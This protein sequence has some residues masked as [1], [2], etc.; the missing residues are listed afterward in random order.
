MADTPNLGN[1][2]SKEWDR[3]Q[4]LASRFESACR[5]DGTVDLDR[6]L[7][8]VGDPLRQ[9][10]LLELIKTDLEYRWKQGRITGLESYL[11]RYSELNG[12]E[13]VSA[14]L[15]Y[16]EYRVRHLYG[17]R[18][19][20]DTY[21]VRFPKQYAELL[22]LVAEQPVQKTYVAID[23]PT[24]T[25]APPGPPSMK[26]S[27]GGYE[28]IQR[29]G[30]GGFG[31]VWK[32]RS[33]GG[34]EV[35]IKVV[36]RPLE[37]EEAQRELKAME[38]IKLLR[39]PFL[40]QTHD[41]FPERERLYIVME[42]A[43]GSLR[44]RLKECHKAG[45]G[46]IPRA[47]LVTYMLE[48][49][50]ALD[51]LHEENLQHRDIKPE[52][53]L[54]LKR[55]A[56]V[57]DFGLAKVQ[58]GKH[59]QT[60]TGSGTPLYMAP[61]IWKGHVH[62]NS[63]QYSLALT[64]AELRLARRPF[65]GS[66]LMQVMFAHLEKQP[67]LTGMDEAEQQVVLRALSKDPDQ[68]YPSCLA[69]AQAL[70]QA[71][72]SGGLLE[73]GLTTPGTQ[74]MPGGSAAPGRG[75]VTPDGG[76]FLTPAGS[77]K[78]LIPAEP[79]TWKTLDEY[80][81]PTN[82]QQN[83]AAY[84]ETGSDLVQEVPSWQP[85]PPGQPTRSWRK[86]LLTFGGLL[87]AGLAAGYFVPKLLR[88]HD[89]STANA[90]LPDNRFRSDEGAEVIT[91]EDNRL[92]Y[93][94]LVAEVEGEQVRF[95]LIPRGVGPG[96]EIPSFYMMEN[97]VWNGLLRAA[98]R[99]RRFHELLD[100]WANRPNFE[101]TVR[102]EWLDKAEKEPENWPARFLTVTEAGCFADWLSGKLPTLHQYIKASGF[103]KQEQWGQGPFRG[104]W[105]ELKK[106]NEK[107]L[108]VA[109]GRHLKNPI[110]VGRAEADV[111]FY[112]IRD[113]SG[114]GLEWTRTLKQD[115]LRKVDEITEP[116]RDIRIVLFAQER[117]SGKPLL[118][119]HIRENKFVTEFFGMAHDDIGFRVALNLPPPDR[120]VQ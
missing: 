102:R 98:Y 67:D 56:K 7:P 120:E 18:P 12:V 113:L 21:Q 28:F 40:L 99:D 106:I 54:L 110:P 37:H 63:D 19:Q 112:G 58:Q 77:T 83:S 101:W 94:R 46:G 116:S 4:Q 36:L 49:A 95:M 92:L 15:I 115:S 17:D 41:F 79:P 11:E 38:L 13:G 86:V 73:A 32:A 89:A 84:A 23:Q 72:G 61:E 10:A 52:N 62:P 76:S 50:E 118:F 45:L 80:G 82:F 97:K 81:V 103:F 66:D 60:A 100:A 117:I 71:T 26:M 6:F 44:D 59:M 3:L 74:N 22:R 39:H 35:A 1:L 70:A 65:A 5:T 31:E 30:V 2:D 96:S 104:H 93:T 48:A 8:P 109:V 43:D 64:Y 78:T 105:E 107:Q 33:R 47:E 24:P 91:D 57:A 90:W 119:E 75:Q 114:N 55:H 29:L 68:R 34:I 14:R 111:S 9:T 16:E 25:A 85:P 27:V 42:L 88:S 69:F 20:L 108:Q 51:Y 87:L 53:I